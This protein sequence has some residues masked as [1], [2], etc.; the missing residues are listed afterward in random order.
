[1]NAALRHT[2]LPWS[3]RSNMVGMSTLLFLLPACK[4]SLSPWKRL[5]CVL[6]AYVSY[7]SDYVHAGKPHLSHGIDRIVAACN[8]VLFGQARGADCIA[9]LCY[10]MSMLSIRRQKQRAYEMWHTLWHVAGTHCLLR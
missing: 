4:Q 1:M 3:T 9:F 7:L 5:S 2:R 10:V 6:Q 8:I